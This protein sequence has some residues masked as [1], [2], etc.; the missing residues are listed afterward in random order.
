[1]LLFQ[2]RSASSSVK[3]P[4]PI[5]RRNRVPGR[6]KLRCPLE[7][8]GS[9]VCLGLFPCGDQ[10]PCFEHAFI[11]SAP[12]LRR[13]IVSNGKHGRGERTICQIRLALRGQ[14]ART[15]RPPG[16]GRPGVGF[17]SRR[18]QVIDVATILLSR[19][20]MTGEDYIKTSYEGEPR[21]QALLAGEDR[22]EKKKP[23]SFPPRAHFFRTSSD[24]LRAALRVTL[25]ISISPFVA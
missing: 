14:M 15:G 10:K 16:G 9:R 2:L 5:G 8:R 12:I 3:R 22:P 13:I 6:K 19:K 23:F 24:L 25:G 18:I 20:R 4:P 1:M 17:S 21:A 7:Y 11:E